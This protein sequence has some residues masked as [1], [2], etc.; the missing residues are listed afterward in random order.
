[1]GVFSELD[2]FTNKGI[3][4]NDDVFIICSDGFYDKLNDNDF[5]KGAMLIREKPLYGN[6]L[7]KDL[8]SFVK[9]REERDNISI[10]MVYPKSKSLAKTLFE[11]IKTFGKRS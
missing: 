9:R 7:A 4:E 11:R 6:E 3:I 8:V 1:M 5:H 10:I 2:I